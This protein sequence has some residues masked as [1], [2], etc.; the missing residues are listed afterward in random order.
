MDQKV[1]EEEKSKDGGT[2]VKE[3]G[4]N[5]N[6]LY[7]SLLEGARGLVHVKRERTESF[8]LTTLLK[9]RRRRLSVDVSLEAIMRMGVWSQSSRKLTVVIL[10]VVQ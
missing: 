5:N 2:R 7:D 6:S 9:M 4:V 8:L 10:H 3:R 1:N